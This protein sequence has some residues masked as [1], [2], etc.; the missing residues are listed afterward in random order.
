MAAAC[1]GNTWRRTMVKK[2]WT[3]ELTERFAAEAE[4]FLAGMRDFKDRWRQIASEHRKPR[5]MSD[6]EG[7]IV[8][9]ES[10]ITDVFDNFF[11]GWAQ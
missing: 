11:D 2:N 1:T 3:P 9:I 10:D 8:D 6:A 5:K 4:N 7:Q